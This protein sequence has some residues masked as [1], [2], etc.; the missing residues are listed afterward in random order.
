MNDP[1]RL[2]IPMRLYWWGGLF[3]IVLLAGL[4]FLPGLTGPLMLDDAGNLEPLLDYM[5]GM[6]SATNVIF[7]NGSGAL[8]RPLSMAS[9][10]ANAHLFGGN[11]YAMKAVNL[12]LH[13]LTGAIVVL[14]LRRLLARDTRLAPRADGLALLLGGIWLL[15]PMQVSTVLYVV[16][17]M[18]ILATLFSFAALLV[19]AIGRERI[20]R[21]QRGGTWLLFGIFP[22]LMLLSLLSKENGVLT[23]LLAGVLEWTLFTTRPRSR[24]V[25][26]RA[27]LA[28]FVALP[29]AAGI[30]LLVLKRM[31]DYSGRDFTLMQRLLS[32]ARILWDYVGAW[33]LPVGSSLGIFHDTYP[34]STSLLSPPTTLFALLGWASIVALAWALRHRAPAFAAGVGFYLCGHLLESTAL[35]LELYFEHRNYLPS[36]GLLIA[37]TGL[38]AWATAKLPTATPAFRSAAVLLSLALLLVFAAAT[39]VQS[40]VW[41]N[42]IL[43]WAQQ[44]AYSPTSVRVRAEMS[45]R[46]LRAGNLLEALRQL[47]LMEAHV[48]PGDAMMPPLRR[49]LA[50]CHVNQPVPA[51]VLE[52]MQAAAHGAVS[53]YS[54]QI[55]QA[56][57]SRIEGGDCPAVDANRIADIGKAW[58]AQ[59][60]NPNAKNNWLAR[61]YLSLLLA[62]Q[63]RY[64]EAEAEGNRAWQ[65]SG[66]F[67][68]FGVFLYQLNGTL[69]NNEAQRA[70]LA[71]LERH[72]GQGDG[73]I[74]KAVAQFRATQ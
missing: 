65:D 22:L 6:R 36:L 59:A 13:L 56:V 28:L 72:T 5:A 12:S 24:P 41:G 35:P 73:Y 1:V 37:F 29:V 71:E 32:E 23:P 16:Q 7:H 27:W 40:G 42:E 20:E 57:A 38:I 46:A 43:L 14:L 25:L 26:V 60:P 52:S 45:N 17:R 10:V 31:L 69:E 61:F 58:L 49:I 63:S 74:D 47:E 51:N 9:F 11:V 48:S 50:Y 55:W 54:V 18:A 21:G 66:H 33:L 67:A 19:Y 15:H 68:R 39:W 44:E 3:T 64:A 34:V 70:I 2:S 4:V 8:G 62:S 30:L 53:G